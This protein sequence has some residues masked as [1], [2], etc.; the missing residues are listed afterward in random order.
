MAMKRNFLCLASLH[1]PQC[2]YA[3]IQ[4]LATTLPRLQNERA[5]RRGVGPAINVAL[6]T[7][8]RRGRSRAAGQIDAPSM[9]VVNYIT[10]GITGLNDDRNAYVLYWLTHAAMA[11]AVESYS[12]TG[13]IR[14]TI[15]KAGLNAE[16][17][18]ARDAVYQLS[19]GKVTDDDLVEVER[20]CT[21]SVVP[22]W[23][24]PSAFEEFLWRAKDLNAFEQLLHFRERRLVRARDVL[25]DQSDSPEAYESLA[26]SVLSAVHLVNA[27]PLTMS[28]F[29]P[30][31]LDKRSSLELVAFFGLERLNSARKVLVEIDETHSNLFVA[32][33]GAAIG[34]TS[35]GPFSPSELAVEL[36][37]SA[38]F[39]YG[40]SGRLA[41]LQFLLERR[42]V[43]LLPRFQ[44]EAVSEQLRTAAP[45]ELVRAAESWSDDNMAPHTGTAMHEIL[46]LTTSEWPG[47]P[48]LVNGDEAA[49]LLSIRLHKPSPGGMA[50]VMLQARGR[51]SRGSCLVETPASAESTLGLADAAGYD[52][53]K[54]DE[55]ARV[56]LAS[57]Y[58]NDRR[59][60]DAI[61]A[62]N[63]A[64]RRGGTACMSESNWW[65]LMQVK[66]SAQLELGQLK[67][68][69]S[70]FSD[71]V[72]EASRGE[73][74][75]RLLNP[76]EGLPF[77]DVLL[78]ASEK[79][80]TFDR[81]V[82]TGGLAHADT[83]AA[84]KELAAGL[85]LAGRPSEAI[86]VLD[87]V[88]QAAWELP[89]IRPQLLAPLDLLSIA[90]EGARRLFP[91]KGNDYL[92]SAIE[93]GRKNVELRILLSQDPQHNDI[94]S[95]RSKLAVLLY[96][97]GRYDEAANEE[98]VVYESRLARL[99]PDHPDTTRAAGYLAESLAKVGRGSESSRLFRPSRE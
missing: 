27:G 61:E 19:F 9:A 12:A 34:T 88:I 7:L 75:S 33:Q 13:S 86:D 89:E 30:D 51:A 22:L 28:V 40:E 41:A 14:A 85:L 92:D 78:E 99:G 97:A 70:T 94:L 10:E 87:R 49:S 52:F 46:H 63:D 2:S 79:R 65:A 67:E 68:A 29:R 44:L 60:A 20:L 74:K 25:L 57:A 26:F 48:E 6:C 38:A 83:L 36:F 24:V 59:F 82:A 5:N 11:A 32:L 71:L 90:Y 91:G 4:L 73:A 50:L 18:M 98:Q 62:A 15:F 95:A 1:N 56:A 53:R 77:A 80:V 21:S 55:E 96:M 64:I 58:L 76:Q 45:H 47:H 35:S 3:A 43:S 66:A 69:S 8:T 72:V 16:L 17:D 37:S 23:G 39:V 31:L 84:A 42:A 81:S 93:A 54:A